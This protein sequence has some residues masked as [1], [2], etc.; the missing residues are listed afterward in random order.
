MSTPSN[1]R[2]Y[3]FSEQPE[4]IRLNQQD[5]Y[6]M[7][8]LKSKI[9]DAVELF[10]PWLFNY[11]LIS[12]NEDLIKMFSGIL[13]YSLTTLRSTQTLGEEYAQL[14]QHNPNHT[15]TTWQN[16]PNLSKTR[17]VAFVLLTTV[18]PVIS[19]RFLKKYYNSLKQKFQLELKP[20][21]LRKILI[22]NL[23]DYDTFVQSLFKL[24]LAVF[25]IDGLYL[26]L[27]KRLTSIQYIF[28]RKPQDHGLNFSNIG[29]LMLIQI[30]I[31]VIKFFYKSYK[32]YIKHKNKLKNKKS[33][34]K[35]SQSDFNDL[36]A[37]QDDRS[38]ELEN[39][40]ESKVCPL[41]FDV[42]KNTACTPCGHL[43]CWDCIMK[44]C[45]LK[46]EC[47][48]CRKICKPNKIIQM[49]NFA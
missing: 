18:F 6:Y 38:Q 44:N 36:D 45:L 40:D 49:R 28:V 16:Y 13:Y 20:G 22:K 1:Q 24:H 34:L 25:F 35:R 33:P 32:A 30:A 3:V 9:I 19:S 42:R 29:R 37:G 43:F 26:Q 47:P 2:N 4:M 31:E 8:Y 21:S 14:A 23:P 12:R 7:S 15:G 5:D 39:V 48:Q 41:C 10:T 17:K 27:S 11:R 46:E